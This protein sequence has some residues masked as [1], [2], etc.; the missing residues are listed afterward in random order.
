VRG[1]G[2]GSLEWWAMLGRAK[3]ILIVLAAVLM[4][5]WWSPCCCQSEW[6]AEAG[7]RVLA[8]GS[9]GEACEC[10]RAGD[11]SHRTGC[12]LGSQTC[13]QTMG[14]ATG[15]QGVGA[16]ELQLPLTAWVWVDRAGGDE[17]GASGVPRGEAA[18]VREHRSAVTLLGLRCALIV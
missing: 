10:C 5:G 14:K 9:G 7:A 11:E 2:R 3:T 13:K 8:G 17:V 12:P 1:R 18:K 6:M 16:V 15:V 4:A